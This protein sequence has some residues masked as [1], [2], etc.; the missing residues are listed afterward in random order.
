MFH[1]FR[2]I[3]CFNNLNIKIPVR[4]KWAVPEGTFSLTIYE[5]SFGLKYYFKKIT[6]NHLNFKLLLNLMRL[7]HIGDDYDDVI[8]LNRGF[9]IFLKFNCRCLEQ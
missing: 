9:I 2:G 1:G 5:E 4:T 3:K 8:L 6:K 7:N